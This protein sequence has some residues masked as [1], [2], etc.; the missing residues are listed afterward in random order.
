MSFY[1]S[2]VSTLAF[3][4][5]FAMVEVT[6]SQNVHAAGMISTSQAVAD[7]SRSQNIARVNSFLQRKDVQNELVKRGVSP[8][9]AQQRIASLSDFELQKV[10]GNIETAPAGADVIVIGVGTLLLIIIIILLVR[11]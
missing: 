1:K 6:F 9:E 2:I 11:R 7:Y 3:V 8:H 4:L 5:S 10:A